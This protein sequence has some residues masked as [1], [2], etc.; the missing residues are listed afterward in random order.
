MSRLS[1]KVARVCISCGKTFLSYPATVRKTSGSATHCSNICRRKRFIKEC[2]NCKKVFEVR[3]S[4]DRIKY[5]SRICYFQGKRVSREHYLLRMRAK[6]RKRRALKY[7]AMGDFNLKYFQWLCEKLDYKCVMCGKKFSKLE[8]TID[9]IV[10]ISKQGRHENKNIQPLCMSCNRNK[11]NR[12]FYTI[13][14]IQQYF[15]EY[16][17]L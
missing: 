11:G 13:P 16:N 8:L 17:S 1:V 6:T 3:I 5:C 12:S 4:M 14:E 10:P 2:K 15:I 9:H 7:N